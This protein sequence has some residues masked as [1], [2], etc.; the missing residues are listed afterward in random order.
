MLWQVRMSHM[1]SKWELTHVTS[2]LRAETRYL[3]M[4][5]SISISSCL[6]FSAL[7]LWMGCVG[8]EN[9]LWSVTKMMMVMVTR[10]VKT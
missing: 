7:M 9:R 5:L 3:I 10:R 1:I 2:M 6:K 4:P 8:L